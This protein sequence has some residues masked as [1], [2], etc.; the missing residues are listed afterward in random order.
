[1]ASTA[2][3]NDNSVALDDSSAIS[4]QMAQ[5]AAVGQCSIGLVHVRFCYRRYRREESIVATCQSAGS[6][7]DS[8][9]RRVDR[10][11]VRTNWRNSHTFWRTG[12]RQESSLGKR[13]MTGMLAAYLEAN[14]QA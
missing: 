8:D 5:A 2:A 6:L 9:C 3:S 12:C 13:K 10:S 14:D 4:K 11:V 1:M 7:G